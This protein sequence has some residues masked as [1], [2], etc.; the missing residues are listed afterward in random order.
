MTSNLKKL[1]VLNVSLF[2]RYLEFGLVRLNAFLAMIVVKMIHM[3]TS[4]LKKL[5]VLNVFLFVN[6]L[7]HE[8]QKHFRH[9][10]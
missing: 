1:M 9:L 4:A 6:C 10:N 7:L 2:A 3:M 8:L 5:L